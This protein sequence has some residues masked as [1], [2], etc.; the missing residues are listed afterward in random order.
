MIQL[1][2]KAKRE[3]GDSRAR[4]RTEPRF[5]GRQSAYQ[6][7]GVDEPEKRERERELDV[8]ATNHQPRPPVSI[9]GF[10]TPRIIS[11]RS[12]RSWC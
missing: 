3:C 12:Y 4:S 6:G 10:R 11:V 1:A 7:P 9:R 2:R 5:K 8:S